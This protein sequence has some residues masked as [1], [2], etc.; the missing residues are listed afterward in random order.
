M[1]IATIGR[2]N[3]GGGLG[4]LWK[5]AGHDVSSF[6]REGGDVSDAEVVL[7]AVPGGAVATALENV[8]GLDGKTVIDATN[9][10]DA[11]PPSGFASNAEYV[12][13]VTAGP[14]AKS[15]N[16]FF[17]NLIDRRGETSSRPSN[18]WCGDQEAREV[19]EASTGTRDMT[20]SAPGRYPTPP[21]RR[22]SC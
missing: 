17:A 18:L 12:K 5:E 3:I 16:I 11:E 6:G 9:L 22:A 20:Q 7:L 14:T 10:F 15:F 4:A 8:D 2:G 1:K 13:S 21:C 19:V